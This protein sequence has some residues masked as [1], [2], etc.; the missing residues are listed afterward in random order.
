MKTEMKNQFEG[1]STEDIR[2]IFVEELMKE[3]DPKILERYKHEYAE[4]LA[5]LTDHYEKKLCKLK[6]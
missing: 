3:I 4:T 1:L 5:R 2:K 6:D